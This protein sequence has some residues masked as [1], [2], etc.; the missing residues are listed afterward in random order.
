MDI[1]VVYKSLKKHH[2]K[3]N[4]S[5]LEQK[6]KL[7]IKSFQLLIKQLNTQL[8][9]T[10]QEFIE[11]NP[12]QY[13]SEDA[14]F[15]INNILLEAEEMLKSHMAIA[16]LQYA[17]CVLFTKLNQDMLNVKNFG[18]S[19]FL[20]WYYSNDGYKS[21]DW[22]PDLFMRTGH[23]TL[24]ADLQKRLLNQQSKRT[25][26]LKNDLYLNHPTKEVFS[27]RQLS[28]EI[29][30]LIAMTNQH[31]HQ[32]NS[33]NEIGENLLIQA[34]ADGASPQTIKMLIDSGAY[35][36]N[37][38]SQN[39]QKWATATFRAAQFGHADC[40]KVLLQV[41][42]AGLEVPNQDNASPL[43][44]ASQNG[45]AQ[46]I[47][48]LVDAK[49]IVDQPLTEG[50]TPLIVA[51]QNGHTECVEILIK[52]GADVTWKNKKGYTA[53]V[54]ANYHGHNHCSAA[55]TEAAAAAAAAADIFTVNASKKL[56]S[57]IYIILNTH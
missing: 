41:G 44:V 57:K 20:L 23:R 19:K 28:S 54:M 46:C 53:L 18:L 26:F 14:E 15:L 21:I 33:N 12:A 8:D 49:A 22:L 3:M 51:A 55:L 4:K 9:E 25:S 42:K 24:I 11:K 1:Y 30:R 32:L 5:D 6:K 52:A 40:L 36:I 45:H 16:A 17:D 48:I 38:V 7:H 39:T 31:H 35:C 10:A 29:T 37:E 47:Q 50:S 2:K 56:C 34:A 43:Y 13:N 27:K